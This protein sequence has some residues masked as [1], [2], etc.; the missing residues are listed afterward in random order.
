MGGKFKT[1]KE[2]FKKKTEEI[3]KLFWGNFGERW[4]NCRVLFQSFRLVAGK[5]SQTSGILA[6]VRGSFGGKPEEFIKKFLRN[7]Y[8]EFKIIWLKT[9]KNINKILGRLWRNFEIVL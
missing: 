9:F 4:R 3:S 2:N 5:I 6:E 8:E 1:I 7:F